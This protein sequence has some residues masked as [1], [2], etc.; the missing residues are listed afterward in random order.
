MM[1]RS[2]GKPLEPEGMLF[3]EDHFLLAA[4]L[5]K[6]AGDFPEPEN[7]SFLKY[8]MAFVTCLDLIGR[9]RIIEECLTPDEQEQISRAIEICKKGAHP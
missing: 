1:L 7:E 2:N 4:A 8:C 3:A 6:F 9:I 5:D